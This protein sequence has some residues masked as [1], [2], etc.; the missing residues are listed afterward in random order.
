[1]KII[2][3]FKEMDRPR[4]PKRTAKKVKHKKTFKEPSHMGKKP[5]R[6]YL[7]R[8]EYSLS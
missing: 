4:D 2:Q 1:M 5:M 3:K 6:Y 8:D 7:N